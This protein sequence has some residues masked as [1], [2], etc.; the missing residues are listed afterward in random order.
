ML[1]LPE[2]ETTGR[3]L[4]SLSLGVQP[5]PSSPVCL[6]AFLS[7]PKYQCSA[8]QAPCNQRCDES[9]LA[10]SGQTAKVCFTP[11]LLWVQTVSLQ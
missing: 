6:G 9:P 8:V 2:T 5:F 4:P 10:L 11:D 7:E 3:S 1:S